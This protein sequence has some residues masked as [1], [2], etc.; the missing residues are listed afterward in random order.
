MPSGEA[1]RRLVETIEMTLQNPLPHR[2]RSSGRS[3]RRADSSRSAGFIERSGRFWG[4][5]RRWSH[6]ILICLRLDKERNEVMRLNTIGD[7]HLVECGCTKRK[8]SEKVGSAFDMGLGCNKRRR[9][10]GEAVRNGST[11]SPCMESS[12]SFT[13]IFFY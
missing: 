5:R 7:N 11:R 6:T 1:E 2:G 4:R 8:S 9:R 13:I 10:L 3:R 12:R